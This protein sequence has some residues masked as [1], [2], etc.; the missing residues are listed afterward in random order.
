MGTCVSGI[1]IIRIERYIYIG[2]AHNLNKRKSA[3]KIMLRDNKHTNKFLQNVYN[4]YLVFSFEVLEY[5]GVS[6]IIE[7]EQYYLDH[8]FTHQPNDI[9]NILR[10][11]R[12]SAGAIVSDETRAKLREVRRGNTYAKG[13]TLTED[14]KNKIRN[15][16][17]GKKLTEEQRLKVSEANIIRFSNESEREKLS[18][19]L[20]GIPKRKKK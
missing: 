15:T 6:V 7:R 9:T 12:S 5:C 16:M 19:K 2:S 20:K 11:A 18:K 1:Y 14:H 10:I 4:K 13:R 8:Y 3:H 17:Q